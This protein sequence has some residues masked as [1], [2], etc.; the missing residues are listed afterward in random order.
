MV[1]GIATFFP[2]KYQVDQNDPIDDAI[3]VFLK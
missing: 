2:E 3:G 1:Q